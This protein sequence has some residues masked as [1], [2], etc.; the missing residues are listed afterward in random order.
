MFA[1]HLA[2]FCDADGMGD[3]FHLF[4]NIL[5]ITGHTHVFILHNQALLEP[6][7]MGG[8]AGGAGILVALQGLNT[9]QREHKATGRGHKIRTRTHGPGNITGINQLSTGNQTGAILQARLIAQAGDMQQPLADRDTNQI[10]QGHGRCTGATFAA[11]QRNKVRRAVRATRFDEG[12]KLCKGLTIAVNSFDPNRQTADV[13]HA[14]DEIKQITEI[15]N[16]DM[17]V[18]GIAGR[19]L[20][21]TANI[22]NLWGDFVGG[23]NTALTG[24]G[25]LGKLDLDHLDLRGLGKLA[26][27]VF[28]QT[29]IGIA[30]A[31]FRSAHLKDNVAASFQMIRAEAA[32]ARVHPNPGLGTAAG[33]GLHRRLGN[34]TIR[35]TRQV[36]DGFGHIRLTGLRTDDHRFGLCGLLVQRREGSVHKNRGASSGKVAGGPECNGIAFPGT[37]AFDP[38]TLGAV[39]GQLFAVH[40]KEILAKEFAQ[41]GEQ[42]AKAAQHRVVAA[43]SICALGLINDE[44]NDHSQGN[45]PDHHNKQHRKGRDDIDRQFRKHRH[46]WLLLY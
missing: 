22:G 1:A 4:V 36:K 13:P 7:I 20:F 23:K 43:D 16:L 21:N 37:R 34:G 9:A 42:M 33:Q 28:V 44:Q 29:A 15:I 32:L 39:K 35:H 10:H 18:R 46:H 27:L 5:R 6:R 24:L 3:S 41:F 19:A 26:Q 2:R 11:I 31:V 38:V 14:G 25:T 40:G 8:N 12:E 17:A 30:D 45:Q